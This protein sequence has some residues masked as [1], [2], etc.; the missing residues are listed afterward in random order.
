MHRTLTST[1]V[2]ALLVGVGRLASAQAVQT[3]PKLDLDRYLGKWFEIARYPNR[4][5][6]SCLSDVTAEYAKRADGRL[7]VTNRCKTRDGSFTEA[8][9]VARRDDPEHAPAKLE[10][11][12]APRF[13]SFLPMVW[14]DYWVMALAP[15]YRYAVVGDPKHEYLWILARTPE[16]GA[17]DWAAATAAARA[18]GF[19]PDHLI[20]T[21]QTAP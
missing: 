21:R 19:D 13:L 18:N 15:D 11:C 2:F 5:Q 7:S 9:G 4:F 12:F 1:F 17:A 6:S 3:V 10:V 8:V 14:G 16:L 20:R